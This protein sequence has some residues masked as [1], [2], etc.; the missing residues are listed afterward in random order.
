MTRLALVP[1]GLALALSACGP[2]VSLSNASVDEVTKAVEKSGVKQPMKP[3]NW[4]M[5]LEMLDVDGPGLSPDKKAAMKAQGSATSD[6]C[7]NEA[8]VARPMSDTLVGAP[9]TEC[10]FTKYEMTGTKVVSDMTCPGV[11]G[12]IRVKSTATYGADTFTAEAE[13]E[14][15]MPQGKA[16]SKMRI[17]GKR[18]GECKA[19]GRSPAPTAPAPGGAAPAPQSLDAPIPAPS[20][21]PSK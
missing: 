2:S 1:I 5:K 18:T 8:D 6:R 9:S 10:K 13:T 4:E 20:G 11:T 19:T 16:H 15:P 14:L 12:Q 17:T 3:G 21:A 7:L